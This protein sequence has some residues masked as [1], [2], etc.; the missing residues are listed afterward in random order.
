MF[1]LDLHSTPKNA[2]LHGFVKG[3]AAPVTLY[4][5][6]P[7]PGLPDIR[8]VAVES[9]GAATWMRRDWMRVGA[10]LRSSCHTYA[11]DHERNTTIQAD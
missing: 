5:S 1:I 6:E 7:A 9:V 8:P 4:H 10:D 3:L 2:F 11:Q